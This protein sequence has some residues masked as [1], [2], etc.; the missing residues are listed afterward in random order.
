M[1]SNSQNTR[2][3]VAMS[4][5]VDSS[6]AALLL[7]K[8]GYDVIGVTAIMHNGCNSQKAVYDAKKVCEILGINHYVVDI[9]SEF[10]TNVID[11]F[12]NS[13]KNGITPNPCPIC[14]KNIKWGELRK[15]SHDKLGA[16]FVATGHYASIVNDNGSYKLFRAK[17][18]KKDQLYML[19][20]LTQDDLAHTLFPLSDYIKSEVRQIAREN[21]LPIADSKESQDTCF[22]E[23]PMTTARFLIDKL[24][25]ATG[26]FI[27]IYDNKIL[28]K[29]NGYYKYTIG[30]RKGIGISAKEPLYV[31]GVNPEKNIVYLCYKNDLFSSEAYVEKVNWILDEYKT[32]DFKSLVKIRYNSEAKPANIKIIDE[33]K[34]LITFKEPQSAITP[35]QMAVIYS[36]DNNFLIGG[37]IIYTNNYKEINK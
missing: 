3:A 17:D 36:S 28:G 15:Y 34:I 10:K 8:Q 16:D 5:G 21:D 1:N 29:H 35:G 2:V 14:N 31:Y 37:G 26:N 25:E 22:I 6:V 24:G 18:D 19:Y 9:K 23:P 12:I 27:S 33:D 20:T 32:K 4:G 7:K 30:Q 13:Y 11:Y